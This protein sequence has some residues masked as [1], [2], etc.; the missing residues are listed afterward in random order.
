MANIFRILIVDDEVDMRESLQELLSRE[1]YSI[2][3]AANGK[4]A[5]EKYSKNKYDLVISDIIMPEMDGIGLLK[6]LKDIDPEVIVILITGYGDIELA[7]QGIKEGATNFLLKP[8]DNKKL[9][10]TITTTLQL[11]QS[12]VELE[13]LRSKQKDSV[14]ASFC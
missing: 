4:N 5:L 11:R 13:N 7:V 12:K 2:D 8:W 10:A 1:G 6:N 14:F 9:L 3:E